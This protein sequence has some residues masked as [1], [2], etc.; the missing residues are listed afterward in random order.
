MDISFIL[1]LLKET[2]IDRLDYNITYISMLF[3]LSSY[4]STVF[5]HFLK[6]IA[7]GFISR[8]VLFS[9]FLIVGVNPLFVYLTNTVLSIPNLELKWTVIIGLLIWSF[10]E[11]DSD[12]AKVGK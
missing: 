9:V 11:F 1:T 4:A 2:L 5:K 8:F 6:N 3:L 12:M 7:G 10:I